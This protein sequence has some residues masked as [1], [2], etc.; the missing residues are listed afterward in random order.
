MSRLTFPIIYPAYLGRRQGMIL[1]F[2]FA[3][4]GGRRVEIGRR[5]RVAVNWDGK[6][7]AASV[8]GDVLSLE[9][10]NLY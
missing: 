2:R 9:A 6:M 4:N 10:R 3:L 8:N 7:D 1:L 5:K